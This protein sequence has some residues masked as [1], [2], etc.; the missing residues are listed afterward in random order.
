MNIFYL[1]FVNFYFLLIISQEANK[2]KNR[3]KRPWI[4]VYGHRPMYCTN[5][6]DLYNRQIRN[7]S[8]DD[9]NVSLYVKF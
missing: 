6:Y 8:N 2:P 1:Q 9:N 7:C 3:A 4:V 5:I